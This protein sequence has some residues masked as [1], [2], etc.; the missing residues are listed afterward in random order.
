MNWNRSL[1]L[2][3]VHC[4]GEIGKVAPFTDGLALSD[5]WGS[6]VGLLG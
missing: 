3:Q 2:L 6:Q 1:D 4:Q 5:T